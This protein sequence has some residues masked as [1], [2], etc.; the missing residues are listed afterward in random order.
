MGFDGDLGL[1]AKGDAARAFAQR[2]SSGT[3]S[4]LGVPGFYAPRIPSVFFRP[5]ATI[6]ATSFYDTTPLKTTLERVV[7]FDLVNSKKHD[8]RLSLGSVNVR[9]GQLVYFDTTTDVIRQEHVM[10]SGAL[11][12]GFPAVGIDGEYY[13]DGGVISNTPLEW[14]ANQALGEAKGQAP[15][16]LAFQVDLWAAPERSSRGHD[17]HEGDPEFEPHQV[18]HP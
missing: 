18:P 1:L 9:T 15:D 6:E 5:P 7:D 13:W 4:L 3:A 14:M 8:I 12:P 11:P 16:I 17:P 10:A 2:L